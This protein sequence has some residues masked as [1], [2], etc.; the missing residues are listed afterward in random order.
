MFGLLNLGQGHLPLLSSDAADCCSTLERAEADDPANAVDR[1]T[2]GKLPK[3]RQHERR[4]ICGR[5]VT[6]MSLRSSGL[7][8]LAGEDVSMPRAPRMPL[9][10]RLGERTGRKIALRGVARG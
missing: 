3:Q 8:L 4:A 7:C 2:A 9:A 10:S 1:S 5:Q 6:R